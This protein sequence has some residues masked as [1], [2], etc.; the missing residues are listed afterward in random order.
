MTRIENSSEK[1]AQITGLIE[2]IA[3]QTNLLALNAGVEAAR[4]GDA[5]R[6]FAVVATEVRGLAHRSSEAAKEISGLISESETSVRLGADLVQQTGTALTEIA[7]SITLASGM[8]EDIAVSAKSQAE[9]VAE[10]NHSVSDLDQA[11]QRNA[12]L[13]EETSALVTVLN[14]EASSL[15]EIVRGFQLPD[16]TANDQPIQDADAPAGL[17]RAL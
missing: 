9:G 2:D 4:A 16:G 1:I 17:G 15:A 8:V 14:T 7:E 11:T 10:I 3:F 13:S 6:G 12:A 5:G